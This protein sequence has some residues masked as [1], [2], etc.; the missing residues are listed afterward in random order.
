MVMRD[1]KNNNSFLPQTDKQT[2]YITESEGEFIAV[3]YDKD[4]KDAKSVPLNSINYQS[5]QDLTV[6]E[7][8]PKQPTQKV[9]EIQPKSA[10]NL[11]VTGIGLGLLLALGINYLFSSIYSKE[12]T[13]AA[14]ENEVI[15]QAQP[16]TVTMVEVTSRPIEKTLEASGT[17]HAYELIPV[18]T[19]ATGLQ[20]KNILADEG[21]F[22][23]QGQVL[24]KLNN[25]TLQAE[26]VQA[27]AT[28]R[29]VEARLAELK[30]GA[31]AEEIA[32]AREQVISAKASL[33]QAES[34]LDLVKKRV[35]RNRGL[36]Q[37]GAISLDRLDEILNQE[38]SSRA[39]LDQAKARLEEAKQQLA[40]LQAGVRPEIISQ[41]KAEVS[42]AKGRVQYIQAR[43]Q[44]TI[45]TAPVSGIVATRNARLGEITSSSETLFSIIEDGKLELRLQVPET[46]IRAIKP[47][48]KVRIL[49]GNF[50]VP[51][52]MGTVREVA[53]IIDGDSRQ[54]TVKVDLP[55]QPDLKPGMFLRAEIATSQIQGKTVP[56]KALLPQ[57]D[58]TAIAFVVQ[59]NNTVKAKSV[60]IGE[61]LPDN[62]VEV[63]SGLESSDR[64]VLKG[65][66]YLKDGDLVKI[67][68]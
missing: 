57:A 66:A 39:N 18:M 46:L 56:T 43:I 13:V 48:Q 68:K 38:K 53:P 36:K 20:I 44:E 50:Q 65:A 58:G 8:S 40:E 25:S 19:P 59:E 10:K 60:E 23:N 12:S 32:R 47:E 22:V 41:A 29:R 34:E 3:E 11:L 27:E 17:V 55:S 37:E 51:S 9:S 28:V 54:G 15:P 24:A 45:V 33:S 35:K 1:R 26:L 49:N 64:I 30:A 16:K 62:S 4:E 21:N 31:R 52:I 63:L 42:Q 6:E 2:F 5:K 14:S 67:N 7:P 61:I